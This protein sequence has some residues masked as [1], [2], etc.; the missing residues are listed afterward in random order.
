MLYPIIRHACYICVTL[1][2]L[3]PRKALREV[4]FGPD[5]VSGR[6]MMEGGHEIIIFAVGE[7]DICTT[8]IVLHQRPIRRECRL[9]VN[10]EGRFVVRDRTHKT[11]L[12][13]VISV[14]IHMSQAQLSHRPLERIVAFLP[15]PETRLEALKRALAP[16]GLS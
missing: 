7:G 5:A 11:R 13:L 9:R 6:I 10:A 4:A 1:G 8:D 15:N 12:R 3:I 16:F 14:T 2:R